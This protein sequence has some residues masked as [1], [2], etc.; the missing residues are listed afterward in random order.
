[1][2][3]R[4]TPYKGQVGK[5]GDENFS[6]LEYRFSDDSSMAVYWWQDM[7]PRYFI[8]AMFYQEFGADSLTITSYSEGGPS[9]NVSKGHDWEVSTKGVSIQDGSP[10]ALAPRSDGPLAM[11]Y[12]A[13]SDGNMNQLQVD[14][15]TGN[16]GPVTGKTA[17][18]LS[19]YAGFKY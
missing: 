16:F 15:E 18:F 14:L 7:N 17:P 10:L 1:M 12:M 19:A 2:V 6:D 13:D 8:L 4:T 11:L 5:W 9:V 3:E